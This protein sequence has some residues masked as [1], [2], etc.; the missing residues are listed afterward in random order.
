MKKELIFYFVGNST[1]E[2]IGYFLPYSMKRTQHKKVQES[3]TWN[4]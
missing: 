4:E 3:A 1:Q 2:Y